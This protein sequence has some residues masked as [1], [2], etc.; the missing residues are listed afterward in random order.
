VQQGASA[1]S[2]R[3]QLQ[4]GG[5][6]AAGLGL[7]RARRSRR[8]QKFQGRTSAP[9]RSNASSWL[10]HSR[11]LPLSMQEARRNGPLP[12]KFRQTRPELEHSGPGPNLPASCVRSLPIVLQRCRSMS[13]FHLNT[14]RLIDYWRSRGGEGQMPDRRAIDPTHFPHFSARSSSPVGR[15]PGSTRSAS[16]AALSPNCHAQ[17]LRSQNVLDLFRHKDRLDLKGASKPGVVDRSP[18]W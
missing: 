12:G 8:Q 15:T 18:S 3:A 16:W 1:G 4:G 7:C 13:V 9:A 6:G 11:F 17:D 2:A 14:K 10:R 5:G